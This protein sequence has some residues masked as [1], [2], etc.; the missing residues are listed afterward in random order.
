MKPEMKIKAMEGIGI[1]SDLD[2]SQ[3]VAAFD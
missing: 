2:S 1:D 3:M